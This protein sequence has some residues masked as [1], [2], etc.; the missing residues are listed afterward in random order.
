MKFIN[1][2]SYRLDMPDTGNYY[3]ISRIYLLSIGYTCFILLIFPGMEY[4]HCK[5]Y[6]FSDGTLRLIYGFDLPSH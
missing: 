1:M 4:L 5:R 3:Y 6:R 2:I